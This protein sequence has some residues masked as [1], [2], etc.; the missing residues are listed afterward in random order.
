VGT[1]M[2]RFRCA[3]LPHGRLKGPHWRMQGM[4]QGCVAATERAR[5]VVCTFKGLSYYWRRGANS[6]LPHSDRTPGGG[7]HPPYRDSSLSRS[8]QLTRRSKFLAL[9]PNTTPQL[10]VRASRHTPGTAFSVHMTPRA[11]FA[12]K[13]CIDAATNLHAAIDR[14]FF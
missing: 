14:T 9:Q 4:F 3:S 8:L 11:V 13:V 2:W 7:N 10:N 12:P 1:H 6:Q 5:N